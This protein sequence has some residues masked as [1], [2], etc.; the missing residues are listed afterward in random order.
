M[1]EQKGIVLAFITAI[2][3]GVS[4]FLNALAVKGIDAALFTAMKNLGAAILIVGA[5]FAFKEREKLLKLT[6]RQWG[7]LALIGL[8]GGSVPFL[9]FFQ[10]LSMISAVKGSFLFR[11]LFIF[12]AVFAFFLLK[13]KASRN[14]L[15]G[16]GIALGGNFLLLGKENL[17]SFGAGELLV[18]GATVIWGFEYVLSK[19]IM[20]N[21]QI[22]ARFVGFGRMFFGTAFIFAYLAAVGKIGLMSALTTA[23]YEWV[24]I[25]SALL[26]LFISSWYAALKYAKATTATAILTLGGPITTALNYIFLGKAPILQDAFGLLLI[27]AGIVLVVGISQVAK[28]P[29]MFFNEVRD[30]SLWKE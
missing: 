15:I 18:L 1:S 28:L 12:S 24:A 22:E 8:I 23:H 26:F 4:V 19:W 5:I 10:G 29:K 16:A 11:M 21:K 2:V 17:L 6:A 20:N 7:W 25:T 30:G 14:V 9:M 27:T 3:S 13:E